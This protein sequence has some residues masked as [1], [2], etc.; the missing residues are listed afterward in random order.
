MHRSRNQIPTEGS[1]PL[2]LGF[3]SKH[4]DPNRFPLSL[5]VFRARFLRELFRFEG[6]R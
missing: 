2:R 3:E 5:G 4:T 1:P 6:L